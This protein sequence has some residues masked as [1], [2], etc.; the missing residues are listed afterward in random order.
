MKVASGGIL[1][2]HAKFRY[3]STSALEEGINEIQHPPPIVLSAIVLAPHCF[4]SL[5]NLWKFHSLSFKYGV[6]LERKGRKLIAKQSEFCPDSVLYYTD[7]ML[8]NL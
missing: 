3:S 5:I 2:L 6:Y 4:T 7:H 1:S 8:S